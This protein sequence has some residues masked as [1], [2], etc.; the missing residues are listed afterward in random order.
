M[1]KIKLILIVLMFVAMVFL[2]AGCSDDTFKDKQATIDI[3]NKL[4]KDQPTPTDIDYSLERYNLIRRAY[5]VN[6]QQEKSRAVICPVR[7]P[8]GYIVTFLEGVGPVTSTTVDGK[9][10]SLNSFLTPDTTAPNREYADWLP[11]V[12][13]S[14][15]VND[16][17]IFWFDVTGEYHEWNGKYHY[18]S[19]PFEIE[20]PILVFKE[21]E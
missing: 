17:G 5:W 14:Y 1:K 16:G 15:G 6:G 4:S 21:A 10:S 19:S 8:L 11:D 7:K 9:I 2:M 18:S 13:G 12:D 20:R 3:G